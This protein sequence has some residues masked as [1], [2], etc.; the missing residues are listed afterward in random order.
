MMTGG[1][2][3]LHVVGRSNPSQFQNLGFLHFIQFFVS[4][5]LASKR[6]WIEDGHDE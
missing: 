3:Y 6:S 4:S 2:L 1:E 5:L